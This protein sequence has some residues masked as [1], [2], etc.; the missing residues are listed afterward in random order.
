MMWYPVI[1]NGE[2]CTGNALNVEQII[3]VIFVQTA[4]IK[5]LRPSLSQI[6]LQRKKAAPKN[7][8][9]RVD[10]LFCSGNY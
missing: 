4:E 10:N 5:H 7:S 6:F 9:G 2:I 8:G 1:K 3:K